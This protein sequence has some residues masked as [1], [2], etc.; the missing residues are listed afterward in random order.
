MGILVGTDLVSGD[1]GLMSTNCKD[2]VNYTPGF[3]PRCTY[4]MTNMRR[5]RKVAEQLHAENCK[6]RKSDSGAGCNTYLEG[7][8]NTFRTEEGAA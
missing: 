7:I 5:W 6:H 1:M 2:C 4:L 8:Y 3:C